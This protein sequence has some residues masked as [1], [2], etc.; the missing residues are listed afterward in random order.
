MNNSDETEIG[1][2][3]DS[4]DGESFFHQWYMVAML[5]LAMVVSFVDRQV[6]TLLV[7]PIRRDMDISDT[8]ISLLMG[9]AFAIFYVTMGVP[10]ARL[11]D[12]RSRK[13]IISAGMLLWS[14]ATAA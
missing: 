9:F 5:I 12:S 11:S 2:P 10:I 3:G 8:G 6:I 4:D 1:E 7:E 14:I 13:M